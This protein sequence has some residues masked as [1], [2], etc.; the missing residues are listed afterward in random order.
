MTWTVDDE[1]EWARDN[2]RG[3]YLR[4]RFTRALLARHFRI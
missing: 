2:P 4:P 1:G 3:F